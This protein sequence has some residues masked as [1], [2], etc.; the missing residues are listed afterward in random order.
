MWISVEA[1]ILFSPC[2][3]SDY[4]IDKETGGNLNATYRDT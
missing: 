1:G 3:S 2:D 4:Y